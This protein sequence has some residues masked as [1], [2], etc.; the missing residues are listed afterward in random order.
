MCESVFFLNN[1][2]RIVCCSC[3]LY[4]FTTVVTNGNLEKYRLCRVLLQ[5]CTNTP[6]LA[7]RLVESTRF[8]QTNTSLVIPNGMTTSHSRAE[9]RLDKHPTPIEALQ[10]I[11][12]P[13]SIYS[14]LFIKTLIDWVNRL[15]YSARLEQKPETPCISPL[16][17]WLVIAGL[18]SFLHY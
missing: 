15:C 10:L 18:L 2:S 7:K 14:T 6:D 11:N 17:G 16:P 1:T 5:T 8:T 9:I 13:F 4:S 12:C 3:S